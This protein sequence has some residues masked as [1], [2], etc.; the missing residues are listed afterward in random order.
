MDLSK[1]ERYAEVAN[2]EVLPECNW[3]RWLAY[4]GSEH[5]YPGAVDYIANCSPDVV[6]TMIAHIRA[7][8]AERDHKDMI[9][10]HLE[11]QVDDL[12]ADLADAERLLEDG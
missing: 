1:V 12:H 2:N 6:L 9:I 3:G 10:S 7:L 4:A 5:D 11:C 8:E